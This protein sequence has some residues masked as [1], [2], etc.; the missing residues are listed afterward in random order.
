MARKQ[1]PRQVT[2]VRYLDTEG[3]QVAKGTPG[4]RRVATRSATYYAYLPCPETGKVR[5]YPLR[6]ADEGTAWV[7]LRRLRERLAREAEGLRDPELAA[8]RRPI[9]EHLDEWLEVVAA[10]KCTA[11]RVALLRSR[12]TRLIAEAGWE[13]LPQ[14]TADSCAT[15][16]ARLQ[17]EGRDDYA[18]GPARGRGIS[19]QTR[20]HY[21]GHARQ[22]AAWLVQGGRLTR[23]PLAGASLEV[24]TEVDRRHDRRCPTDLEVSLLFAHLRTG[25]P[26]RCRMGGAQ[27]ALGYELAMATGLRAGELRAL[28]REHLDLVAGQVHLAARSQK[29]RRKG[30]LPLPSWLVEALREWL[31]AGGALWGDFPRKHPGRLLV[32]DLAAAR[33]A[34]LGQPGLSP[35]ECQARAASTVL[36]Y[37]VAGADGPLFLDFHAL[38]HWYCTAMAAMPGISPKVLLDLCRHSDANLTLHT[39]A[40]ARD[41]EARAAVDALPRPGRS[42][43][44]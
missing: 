18:S 42:G 23:D 25:A 19:A 26:V 7:E 38:R 1:R 13:R 40:K 2:I 20:N 34:W 32:A 11:E 3:R 10:G 21:A 29:R 24:N 27:R 4:A 31:A 44:T 28:G 17:E 6:T 16:L 9:T 35:E 33:D 14:L 41:T 39:Y 5:R 22:W 37:E 8:A 12:L 30:G 15:A 36:L 43:A